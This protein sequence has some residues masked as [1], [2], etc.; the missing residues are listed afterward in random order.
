M[1]SFVTPSV[2]VATTAAKATTATTRTPAPAR[3]AATRTPA[4]K[5]ASDEDGDGLLGLDLLSSVGHDDSSDSHSGDDG[6][7]LVGG[8]VGTS[9]A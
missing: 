4:T 6:G 1:G 5:A 9:V 3:A 2:E 7:G 8:L